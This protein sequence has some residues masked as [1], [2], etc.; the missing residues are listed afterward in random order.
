MYEKVFKIWNS[1]I[2]KKEI[3]SI[4]FPD[5]SLEERNECYGR[6]VI[7]ITLE[8]NDDSKHIIL[9]GKCLI[10]NSPSNSSSAKIESFNKGLN[11]R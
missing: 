2:P 7:P 1:E 10:V 4:S 5:L 8:F 9:A 11:I 6:D 3:K